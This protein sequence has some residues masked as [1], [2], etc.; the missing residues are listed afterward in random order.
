[1]PI[2]LLARLNLFTL[3][4]FPALFC[5]AVSTFSDSLALVRCA[6]NGEKIKLIENKRNRPLLLFLFL[7]LFFFSYFG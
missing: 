6:R 2:I 7:L 5:F 4:F 1:M 3:M